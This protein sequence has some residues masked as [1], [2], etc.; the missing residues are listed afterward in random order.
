[1]EV[2][3]FPGCPP[4]ARPIIIIIK[5]R[6]GI[7]PIP[8]T[9]KDRDYKETKAKE[10][11]QKSKT[12]TLLL[13]L[14][15]PPPLAHTALLSQLPLPPLSPLPMQFPLTLPSP[16]NQ[17]APYPSPPPAPHRPPRPL[18]YQLAGGGQ[19]TLVGQLDGPP[20]LGP[21][22]ALRLHN[23]GRVVLQVGSQRQYGLTVPA[24]TLRL[25]GGGPGG[26]GGFMGQ[27]LGLTRM[28]T[29]CTQGRGLPPDMA[30]KHLT[31]GRAKG[32]TM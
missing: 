18:S 12:N 11:E 7:N 31:R 29:G 25:R 5:R 6:S 15:P 17:P 13:Y 20:P 9:V 28:P 24:L 22:A 30:H 32:V 19:A 21:G 14:T 1:M 26:G 16:S 27:G 10:N 23:A 3:R 2:W 4:G 8:T